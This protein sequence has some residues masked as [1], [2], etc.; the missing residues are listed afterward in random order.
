MSLDEIRALAQCPVLRID[1]L[2]I[3]V[4]VPSK[5]LPTLL[6]GA[7]AIASVSTLVRVSS[8]KLALM[9][10]GSQMS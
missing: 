2:E 8:G 6:N 4:D 3:V 1:L 7:H 9:I 10:L 5:L